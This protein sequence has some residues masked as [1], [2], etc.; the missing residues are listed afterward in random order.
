MEDLSDE[1]LRL[2][3]SLEDEGVLSRGVAWKVRAALRISNIAGKRRTWA[4]I[5]IACLLSVCGLVSAAFAAPWN[6]LIALCVSL[7]IFMFILAF[8][9]WTEHEGAK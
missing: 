9:A 1:D 4:V 7:A 3:Q 2:L 6:W 5:T 8:V